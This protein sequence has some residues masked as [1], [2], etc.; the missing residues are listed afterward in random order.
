[1]EVGKMLKNDVLQVIGAASGAKLRDKTVPKENREIFARSLISDYRTIE[2]AKGD[3]LSDIRKYASEEQ[4]SNNIKS[5]IALASGIAVG[6]LG[7][8]GVVVFRNSMAKDA[9][10]VAGICAGLIPWAGG[11]IV[12]NLYTAKETSA[13]AVE[14]TAAKW[15]NFFIEQQKD[16]DD[17][18]KKAIESIPP[19]VSGADRVR[20]VA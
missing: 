9:T 14:K 12:S 11:S 3:T 10:G 19:L 6:M 17:A 18:V 16:K 8:A 13:K 2:Q 20:A 4:S 1:M 7:V 15:E 5:W